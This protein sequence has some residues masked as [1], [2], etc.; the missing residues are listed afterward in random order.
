MSIVLKMEG[1]TKIFPKV[2]AN[3][4]I[5]ITLHKGEVHA[6]LGE[7]GAGKST[8]MNCLYGLYRPDEGKIFIKDREVV[9][10]NS[11]DAIKNGIGMVHQHF[12]L[13]PEL[14]VTEN[15]ILGL[16]QSRAPLLDIDEA[17]RKIKELSERYH[18]NINPHE[19]IK[20]LSVGM[21]QRVEIL[22]VLYREAEILVLDEAT[23]VLTP[24]EVREL[25][26]VIRKL[27]QEGRSVLIITHK[28]EEVMGLSDVVT[29]LRDG[30]VVG[31]VITK[32]TDP[33]EL[34][35]MM[36]GRD[37][38]FDF[39]ERHAEVGKPI[40]S[41]NDISVTDKKGV[42]KLRN[43]SFSLHKGEILGIAGVDGNG[44]VEL[45]E[46][47]TGMLP[48]TGGNIT[49]KGE[50]FGALN[51]R[52][53]YEQGVS[54][55]PQDRQHTGLVLGM[56]LMKNL[57]LTDYYHAP[58]SKNNIID[59]DLVDDHAADMIKQYNIKAP[60]TET[61]ASELS[62]GNQQKIILARELCRE[63]DILIA[64]QPTR[65]LDI[66]ATE[67][68]RQKLIDQ[69][70]NGSAVLLISTEL[71]EILQVADRIAVIHE[72]QFMGIV[73]K[74]EVDINELGLMMAGNM[75]SPSDSICEGE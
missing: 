67:F 3:D 55:I 28:L 56:S 69:R 18:F 48:F 64:V 36:V 59:Y 22:K 72:G 23:A 8:L 71:E 65:G 63:P 11:D 68:L 75:R 5:S 16:R 34:A 60:T 38:L 19:K 61:I 52:I 33:K 7:N 35:R 12:M 43:L 57:I 26:G 27:V 66:G 6:L 51:P 70:D 74:N 1:I 49:I 44:Q 15:I 32:K 40:M 13:I 30:K 41:V 37:V 10:Q 62:G 39:H 73:R 47:I 54:H 20:N 9:I 50:S 29:V 24:Q 58:Y 46:V 4:H 42:R 2:I 45:S 25:F 53:V 21:Q 17:G 31:N 14:T